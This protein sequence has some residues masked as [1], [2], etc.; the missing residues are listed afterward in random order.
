[1]QKQNGKLFVISGP[2][3]AGK[4]TIVNAVMDQADPSGTALSISM[5]TREPRP[6][7][8]DGVNYFFVTKEEFRRQIEAGGFLEYAEVY[9]HYYGTPKSKV[10]EKLNQGKDVILEI[11]I[12]GA[13]NVKKAFP[14]GVLI[15]ILPPSMEVLR[16]RLTGRGTDAPEV[17][18]RRLS[19]TWGELTFIDRYDYGVVND[20]LEEAVE[21]VQAI[22]RAE[23]ARVDEN[24]HIL[25]REKYGEA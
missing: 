14:E 24:L 13:L 4:G 22:M 9:D 12:Q 8:E 20:D 5:T 11:D 7:E 6:G 23:H 16:S 19:K 17:I 1:M 3:G 21:T 10:M 18:E 15:F 2:S 25:I